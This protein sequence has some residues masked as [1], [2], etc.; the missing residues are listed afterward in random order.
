MGDRIVRA[1][2]WLLFGLEARLASLLI[3]LCR[4]CG[5]TPD[6]IERARDQ[7]KGNVGPASMTNNPRFPPEPRL[8]SKTAPV[9][10]RTL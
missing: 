8:P 6:E 7:Q 2:E 1:I 5:V 9:P 4:I 3:W 10:K